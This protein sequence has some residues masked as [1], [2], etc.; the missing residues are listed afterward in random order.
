MEEDL[1]HAEEELGLVVGKLAKFL[2]TKNSWQ[3]GTI[4]C[5]I[6]TV[7]VLFFLVLYT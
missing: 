7:V 5:L 6:A 3:L 2:H 1:T 4:L